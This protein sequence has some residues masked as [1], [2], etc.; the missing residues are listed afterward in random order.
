VLSNLLRITLLVTA[1]A[2]GGSLLTAAPVQAARAGGYNCKPDK[3]LDAP[4]QISVQ[5][6]SAWRIHITATPGSDKSGVANVES[7]SISGGGGTYTAP[8]PGSLYID[9]AAKL[10]AVNVEGLRPGTRY[11]IIATS[12]DVCGNTGVSRTA[13]VT[14][15]PSVQETVAPTLTTPAIEFYWALITVV[16]AVVVRATDDTAVVRVQFFAGDTLVQDTD[17]S[18]PHW[19]ADADAPPAYK[20]FIS[21][22]YRGTTQVMRVV[23]TD[24]YGNTR[25]TTATLSF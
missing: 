20:W 17:L 16:P 14:M 1:A 10:M 19:W 9:D 2:L 11:S 25:T 6:Q 22:Q 8:D 24:A 7:Y 23:A 21:N 3:V 13:E 12:R 18:G 4:A 5:I 15:G